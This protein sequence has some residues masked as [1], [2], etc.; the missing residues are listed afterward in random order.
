MQYTNVFDK[1]F[2]LQIKLIIKKIIKSINSIQLFL[3]K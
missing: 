2:K 3:I 1:K